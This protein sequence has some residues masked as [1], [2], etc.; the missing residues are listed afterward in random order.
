MP[1]DHQKPG[2]APLVTQLCSDVAFDHSYSEKDFDSNTFG[3]FT[4][5]LRRLLLQAY[6]F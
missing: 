3:V 2:Y 6:A 1:T 4:F 5:Y